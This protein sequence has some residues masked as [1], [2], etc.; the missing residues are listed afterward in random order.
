MNK[1]ITFT[2]EGHPVH[3]SIAGIVTTSLGSLLGGGIIGAIKSSRETFISF[4]ENNEATQFRS[5]LD[6]KRT[7]SDKMFLS[8]GRGFLSLGPRV[9]LFC[10]TFT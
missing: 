5:H 3:P 6:A 8:F 10:T 9:C 4:I 1:N 7:L 2:S